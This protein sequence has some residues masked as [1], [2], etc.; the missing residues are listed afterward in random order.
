MTESGSERGED[1]EGVGGRELSRPTRISWGALL[2]GLVLLIGLGWLFSLL[3][4]ALGVSVASLDDVRAMSEGFGIGATIWIV[5]SSLVV[6]FLGGLFTASLAGSGD[7]HVGML[8]GLTL[9]GLATVVVMLLGGLGLVVIGGG[10]GRDV[11]R[12]SVEVSARAGAQVEAAEEGPAIPF[13]AIADTAV[14]DEIQAI[15]VRRASRAIADLDA[16]GGA[17]VSAAELRSAVREIDGRT[18]VQAAA[19]LAEGDID[20]ARRRLA[21]DT[22]LS[23]AEIDALAEGAIRRLSSEIPELPELPAEEAEQRVRDRVD[24]WTDAAYS[25]MTA[26]LARL[27]G[28]TLS[29]QEVR[30]ALAGLD[31][32]TVRTVARHIASGEPE[33][34]KDVLV[35]RTTLSENEI[36]ALVD[37]VVTET[38]AALE[39]AR[40]EIGQI[41]ETAQGYV[42]ALVW[43]AFLGALVALLATV[44]GGAVGA[45]RQ[46]DGGRA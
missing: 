15:L 40:Q 11:V 31:R 26:R 39:V 2:A 9:W 22:R 33:R 27:A 28:P 46:S 24:A 44:W 35:A 4:I 8:H 20:A 43:T 45:S 29:E 13:E 30:R 14:F 38:R 41:A 21:R 34:A 32:E 18:L 37:R 7:R 42:Q 25:Q 5:L 12:T 10:M 1:N 36:D 23:V 3:G 17:D 19:S 16:P 6:Y